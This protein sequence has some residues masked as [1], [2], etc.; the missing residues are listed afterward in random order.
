M[1]KALVVAHGRYISV[2]SAGPGGA[3]F[4]VGLPIAEVRAEL[5]HATAAS[6]RT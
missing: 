5:L 4:T 6:T 2:A 1:A 3:T